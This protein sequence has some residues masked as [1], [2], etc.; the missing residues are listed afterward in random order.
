MLKHS[1]RRV[2]CTGVGCSTST[3]SSNKFPEVTH[4]YVA[5][6]SDRLG[7]LLED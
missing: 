5:H 1:A 7:V 3:H 4:H 6:K 2:Q